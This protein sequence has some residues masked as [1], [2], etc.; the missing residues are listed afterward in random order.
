ML[1]QS[2][3]DSRRSGTFS[4]FC[5]EAG[6]LGLFMVSAC[7]FGALLEHPESPVHRA[8]GNAFVRRSLMGVAMG[9]TAVTLIYSY[10]GRR[11]G[12]HMNPAVTLCAL[13]LGRIGRGDAVGYV[14]AQ[15]AGAVGGVAV[16]ALIAGRW[17]GHPSVNFVVT[18]P[19]KDVIAA[20]FAEAGIAGGMMG[21]SLGLNR[22]PR[23][24]PYTG[25]FA[26]ILV[27][28]YITFEAPISGMSMNPARSFGAA[29][30]AGAWMHIWIYF[31]A[32]VAG[33]LAAAEVARVVSREPAK[34]C[35][36]GSHGTRVA[37]HC[38]CECLAAATLTV[39]GQTVRS[40]SHV[41]HA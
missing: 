20:W 39:P 9:A 28:L 8:I 5:M 36:K 27:A 3:M 2:G 14:L 38:P 12:A 4:V 15:F 16:V 31:T 34:L 22:F 40:S 7:V 30:W 25:I 26:G 13:R 33:M 35:C 21:M 24:A 32:P 19:G 17:V 10:W 18:M 23:L 1:H 37:C 29:F 6:L 41:Q 11:S